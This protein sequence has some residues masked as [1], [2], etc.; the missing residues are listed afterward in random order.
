MEQE[1]EEPDDSAAPAL[2]HAPVRERTP[3]G[4]GEPV[5]AA[6]DPVYTTGEN[7]QAPDSDDGVPRRAD[8][9]AFTGAQVFGASPETDEHEPSDSSP[10]VHPSLPAR[11]ESR[12]A[13]GDHDG[14]V[15]EQPSPAKAVPLE[16]PTVI[17]VGETAEELLPGDSP[18]FDNA[19]ATTPRAANTTG[20]RVG[21]ETGPADTGTATNPDS[22]TTP[23]VAPPAS[24][25]EQPAPP[26]RT[27]ALPLRHNAPVSIANALV[28]EEQV[29]SV[30]GQDGEAGERR[31][32]PAG[33]SL[34]ALLPAGGTAEVA[35]HRSPVSAA[36]PTTSS[37]L[38]FESTQ[39]GPE[40]REAIRWWQ[41][42]PVRPAPPAAVRFGAPARST[43]TAAVSSRS[44]ITSPLPRA[45]A[46]FAPG[47][48]DR[49]GGPSG[50][51]LAVEEQVPRSVAEPVSRALGVEVGDLPVRRG[52]D[53]S[54]TARELDVRGYTDGAVMHVP[55][56]A[57]ALDGTEAAPLVAHELTHVFQQR[58]FGG[59][60][61]DRSSAVGQ[62]LEQDAV[63]IEDWVSG[64]ATGA[65]PVLLHPVVATSPAPPED[66]RA[67][68]SWQA[69]PEEPQMAEQVRR[70]L[71]E[72][73]AQDAAGEPSFQRRE[74]ASLLSLYQQVE[75]DAEN[76]AHRDDGT[77]D[78]NGGRRLG[79]PSE[80]D[81]EGLLERLAEVLA[82]E[83]PRRWFDLDDVDEFEELANRIY[84]QL[85]A[86]LR[87]D[88]LVERERSGRLMDF[89]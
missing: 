12:P 84:N 85:S 67:A 57:G 36:V 18:T 46:Q 59:A 55:G 5:V 42:R 43:G 51:A 22:T 52:A 4:T 26:Q 72:A 15:E 29:T 31:D 28:R 89:G 82:D 76:A 50:I 63:R 47:R 9:A 1:A 80:V 35:R 3:R 40:V 41:E 37:Q 11:V 8:A 74:A 62:E 17:H 39:D 70:A 48:R 86:R 83:P 77:T 87:F 45:S 79:T 69:G 75:R 19:G 81:E 68:A 33:E 6:A 38:G 24:F 56:E 34:R 78:E 7:V 49:P 64:G 54:R 10:L 13:G 44:A 2:L 73:N 65:P 88:M 61:P 66:L 53:A 20:K 14:P 25:T 58:H 27:T 16:A 71:E 21:D 60:L 32:G 23:P 30:V